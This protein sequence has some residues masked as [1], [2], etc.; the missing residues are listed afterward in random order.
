MKLNFLQLEQTAVEQMA[1]QTCVCRNRVH[2]DLLVVNG[3]LFL[4]FEACMVKHLWMMSSKDFCNEIQQPGL[5][6]RIARP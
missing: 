1:R 6:H 2:Y 3:R 5:L 4:E